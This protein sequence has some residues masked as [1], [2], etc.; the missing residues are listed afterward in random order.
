MKVAEGRLKEPPVEREVAPPA[1]VVEQREQQ[2]LLHR[3]H[4]QIPS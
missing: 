3:L 1:L 4:H 2:G